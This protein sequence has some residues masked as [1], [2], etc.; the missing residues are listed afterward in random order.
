MAHVVRMLPPFLYRRETGPVQSVA[1]VFPFFPSGRKIGSADAAFDLPGKRKA[2]RVS[3]ILPVMAVSAFSFGLDSVPQ[4]TFDNG[5]VVIF[6]DDQRFF[7]VIV[8]LGMGQIIRGY[9]LFLNQIAHIFFIF[10]KLQQ[11]APLPFCFSGRTAISCLPQLPGDDGG[12]F[13]L[14]AVLAEDQPDKLRFLRL[15][16]YLSILYLIPQQR[17]A[18]NH[19]PLHLAGLAPFHPGRGFPTL[20]L[21]HRGHDRQ[22][23][24]RVGIQGAD[25]VVHEKH[26]YPQRLQLPG[27]GNGVQN[28]SGKT[29]DLFGDDQLKLSFTGVAD[30]AFELLPLFR[31]GA[32]DPLV[33]VNLIQLPA[34][35]VFDKFF[36]I[37]LLCLK[38]I[39]LVL[40]FC[41]DTAIA[42]NFDR[43]AHPPSIVQPSALFCLDFL[44]GPEKLSFVQ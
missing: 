4:S 43:P 32:G 28:I 2:G 30:H 5:L 11:I 41:G 15:Y 13:L 39:S 12:P 10:Q 19:A 31:G 29:A 24:L 40:L 18:E 21:G 44:F 7:A 22:P 25:A 34:F 42:R 20:L 23:E 9:G 35:T 37:P 16:L 27:V 17:T 33:G 26:P 6:D 8:F 36:K 38:R 14:D 1:A 3:G